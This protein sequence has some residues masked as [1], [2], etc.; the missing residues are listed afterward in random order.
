VAVEAETIAVDLQRRDPTA[1]FVAG[2]LL[3]ADDNLWNRL[4][5]SETAFLMQRRLEHVG[6]PM[7]VLPVRVE[8]KE[9]RLAVDVV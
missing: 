4:L 8:L 6:V 2:Q 7:I 9:R 1:V 3:F 5:H